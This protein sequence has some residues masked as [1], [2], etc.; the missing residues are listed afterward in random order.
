M[1]CQRPSAELSEDR[2]YMHASPFVNS[3]SQEF[4]SRNAQVYR[5]R[6]TLKSPTARM[7]LLV[8]FG[9]AFLA[10]TTF[11]IPPALSSCTLGAFD[12]PLSFTCTPTQTCGGLCLTP[13]PTGTVIPCTVGNNAPCPVLKHLHPNAGL[14]DRHQCAMWRTMSLHWAGDAGPSAYKAVRRWSQ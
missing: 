2:I 8:A 9:L 7:S 12:C 6:Y 11:A 14:S 1:P 13:Q 4:H 5:S 3:D 10:S